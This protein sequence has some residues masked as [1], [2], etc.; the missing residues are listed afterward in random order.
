MPNWC[1]IHRWCRRFGNLSH[2]QGVDFSKETRSTHIFIRNIQNFTQDGGMA[3]LFVKN[4]TTGENEF[5]VSV[6]IFR[7][8][9]CVFCSDY[10]TN[11]CLLGNWIVYC[12]WRTLAVRSGCERK[13]TSIWNRFVTRSVPFEPVKES[14]ALYIQ[15]STY[16]NATFSQTL[17]IQMK[18]PNSPESIC[19]LP[20]INIH[21]S[22][23]LSQVCGDYQSHNLKEQENMNLLTV[24]GWSFIPSEICM[25]IN[26]LEGCRDIR[27]TELAWTIPSWPGKIR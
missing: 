15:F 4:S 16:V 12:N 10:L 22:A 2:A 23:I 9:D 18:L 17:C 21:I 1:R 25:C 6:N 7:N 24:G 26:M 27:N 14:L 11:V 8:W 5:S 20:M 13:I 19:E 3:K